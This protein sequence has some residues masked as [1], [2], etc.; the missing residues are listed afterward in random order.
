MRQTGISRDRRWDRVTG[1]SAKYALAGVADALYAIRRFLLD[2]PLFTSTLLPLIP[3]PARW[4]LR[5]AYL[6]PAD[7]ID[8]AVGRRSELV[9]P[10]SQMFVGSVDDFESSGELLVRRLVDVA[11]LTP[12]SSVLD[13]GSGIGRLAVALTSFHGPEGSYDGLDIV[14]SG[15]EWCTQNITTRHPRF[16]F[17]LANVFNGEYNPRGTVQP[18]EYRLPYPDASFD[19]VV[20]TSVFTHMLPA[21]MEHYIDEIARV[22]KPGGRCFA[23]YSLLNPESRRLMESGAGD[24]RFK[25]AMGPCAVVDPMVPELAVAYE[26]GYVREIYK[27]RGLASEGGIYYGGW[28]GREQSDRSSGLSQDIVLTTRR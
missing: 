14:P 20:L 16:R 8:K 15:I 9:P 19:L 28:S 21:D 22:L 3:R 13:I 10:R 26:E 25:H 18:S 11:G 17:T 24:M 5:R 7:A 1:R 2:Q 27:E 12:E 23:T 6:L 4:A